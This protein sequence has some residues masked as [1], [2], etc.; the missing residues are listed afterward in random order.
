MQKIS[1]KKNICSKGGVLQWRATGANSWSDLIPSAEGETILN[2]G[3]N[4]K[5]MVL[6]TEVDSLPISQQISLVLKSKAFCGLVAFASFVN[7]GFSIYEFNEISKITDEI[8]VKDYRNEFEKIKENFREHVNELDI[9]K[10]DNNNNIAKI[11]EVRKKIENDKEELV[12][13]IINIK[14]DIKLLQGKKKESIKSLVASVGLAA[15]GALGMMFGVGGV[16]V[17]HAISTLFNTISGVTN[18]TNIKNCN[19]NIKKL[20][21]LLKEAEEE[22]ILMEQMLDNL[23]SIIEKKELKFPYFYSN[24]EKLIEMQRIKANDYILNINDF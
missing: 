16:K 17:V 23:N 11:Q 12:K 5:K 3:F 8:V 10:D 1:S 22:K 6:K 4:E 21:D 13:L 7:L 15:G 24:Y 18:I 19:D 9:K 14:V 20:E 2:R